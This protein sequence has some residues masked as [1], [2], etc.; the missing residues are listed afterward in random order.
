MKN[1][2]WVIGIV[3]YTGSNTKIFKNSK[4]IPM[5]ISNLMILMNKLLYTVF[6][7]Q[8]ILC[9]FFAI[10]YMMWQSKNKNDLP[11]LNLYD[12]NFQIIENKSKM[13]DL[14]RKF[15]TYLVAYSH[16]I[17][18]SLYVAMEL[19]KMIQS[20]LIY[21]DEVM[22]DPET[23]VPVISKTS[24]LVEELGQIKYLFTDKT[25][26]LTK[27]EMKF[28]KCF[29][30]NKVYGEKEP[31]YNQYDEEDLENPENIKYNINGD[32]R[33]FVILKSQNKSLRPE[34]KII[35]DFFT[36][37]AVCHSALLEFDEKE[38]KLNYQV[39]I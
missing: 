26:T 28:I 32:R 5:K 38:N 19:V 17:P 15:L 8:I 11:Y 39:G 29:I 4:K 13:Q 18:I 14:F 3:I 10:S 36:I 23:K 25:G 24:D 33:A 7:F 31:N 2:E 22:I 21:F 6:I 35:N 20:I 34:K 37:M 16:L 9:L 27:N 12:K 1:T 30:N